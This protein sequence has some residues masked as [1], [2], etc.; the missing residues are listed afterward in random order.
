M[1]S[2]QSFNR[3]VALVLP[4]NSASFLD[5]NNNLTRDRKE[6]IRMCLAFNKM[7]SDLQ[8]EVF[9]CLTRSSPN[10]LYRLQGEL[11]SLIANTEKLKEK[12]DKKTSSILGRIFNIPRHQTLISA[13]RLI[14][15]AQI[16]KVMLNNLDHGT[17]Q[18]K[19]KLK[20]MDYFKKLTENDTDK[21]IELYQSSLEKDSPLKSISQ[22]L[23]LILS[24]VASNKCKNW[25]RNIQPF[26]HKY[27]SYV[28]S[29]T[30]SERFKR[31][32]TEE[33]V[34]KMLRL[35]PYVNLNDLSAWHHFKFFDFFFLASTPLFLL[36]NKT[37]SPNRP[38][39]HQEMERFFNSLEE[40]CIKL[41]PR[42]S[43]AFAEAREFYDGAY[44]ETK[45]NLEVD[46]IK[47]MKKTDDYDFDLLKNE[48]K[49]AKAS[50]IKYRHVMWLP[51]RYAVY[52][53]FSPLR[54]NS[55]FRKLMKEKLE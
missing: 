32:V 5:K 14:R 12:Y 2:I 21:L 25:N 28:K 55:E 17:V 50:K 1:V 8:K 3:N 42:S 37:E 24:K 51:F 41:K 33:D 53:L 20:L 46:I 49:S 52:E 26:R 10:S 22:E 39:F 31:K 47:F 7:Q 40:K 36:Q 38:V 18:K 27:F 34:H 29:E 13:N 44:G 43:L 6:R 16:A 35:T 19:I 4:S 23:K 30:L 45:D 11:D 48:V 15:E 9:N 54:D